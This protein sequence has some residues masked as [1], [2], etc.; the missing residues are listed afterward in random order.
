MK[1]TQTSA[2]QGAKAVMIWLGWADNDYVAA[3]SLLRE[4]L[5]IQATGLANTAIEKYLKAVFATLNLTIPR[6]HNVGWLVDRLLQNGP[7]LSLN[8]SFLAFLDKAYRLRY[9]D[10]LEEDF[11]VS[12]AKVKVLT[13]LDWSV[14]EIRKRFEFKSPGGEPVKTGFDMLLGKKD[15]R[16]L[17]DN[18]AYG[19]ASRGELFGVPT[20]CYDMRVLPGHAIME[21]QY[22]A[23]PI[24]DDREFGGEALRPSA[25]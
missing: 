22:V 1:R 11:N 24:P 12:V 20:D 17:D 23:G 21:A 10:D 2:L 14:Y 8:R 9:P 5:L 7:N 16:L 25:E 15:P 4:N 19:T 13:E 3:R 18:C 6:S